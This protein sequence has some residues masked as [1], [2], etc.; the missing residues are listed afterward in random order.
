MTHVVW[1][2][3]AMKLASAPQ[4]GAL[5][6]DAVARYEPV[7]VAVYTDEYTCQVWAQRIARMS[8]FKADSAQCQQKPAK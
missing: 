1:V 6:V 7:Q 3:M 8:G 2:L 5:T 4:G